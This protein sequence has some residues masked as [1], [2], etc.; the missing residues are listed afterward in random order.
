MYLI[1]RKCSFKANN[2]ACFIINF[3]GVQNSLNN[4]N[5]YKG[6][7]TQCKHK[8]QNVKKQVNFRVAAVYGVVMI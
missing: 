6:T 7:A 3:E 2:K 1:T 5:F 4:Y 8:W